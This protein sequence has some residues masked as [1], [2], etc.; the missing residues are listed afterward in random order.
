MFLV[1]LTCVA[2]HDVTAALVLKAT[3]HCMH[4]HAKQHQ[5]RAPEMPTLRFKTVL[6]EAAG[7]SVC[8]ALCSHMVVVIFTENSSDSFLCWHSS[9]IARQC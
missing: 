6:L 8:A 4:C 5:W 7:L 1:A 3:L 2:W 9:A